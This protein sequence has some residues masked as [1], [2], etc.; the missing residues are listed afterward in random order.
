MARRKNIYI[1][2]VHVAVEATT[3]NKARKCVKDMIKRNG[4]EGV[5]EV[6]VYD[7]EW[8]GYVDELKRKERKVGGKWVPV[9][10]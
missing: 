2:V 6:R 8:A 3:E 1:M 9:G 4:D 5:S 7:P 10:C